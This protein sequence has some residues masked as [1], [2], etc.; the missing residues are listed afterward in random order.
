VGVTLGGRASS[1]KEREL[2]TNKLD[3]ETSNSEIKRD[4]QKQK[5]DLQK[6]KEITLG[7]YLCMLVC[8]SFRFVFFFA[9]KW[10]AL[11][12]PQKGDS[13]RPHSIVAQGRLQ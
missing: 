3:T 8:V 5:R 6:Q 7:T 12:R 10:R 2:E 4:V 1:N 9:N 13:L 11:C